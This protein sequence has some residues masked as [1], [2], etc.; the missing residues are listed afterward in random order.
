MFVTRKAYRRDV[1][2]LKAKIE[3]LSQ[4][5]SSLESAYRERSVNSE[6]ANPEA[7]ENYRG[8]KETLVAALTK[9]IIGPVRNQRDINDI[10]HN[11]S[12]ILGVNDQSIPRSVE[13][14]N[15]HNESIYCYVASI[16][17]Y[18]RVQGNVKHPINRVLVWSLKEDLPETRNARQ[19]SLAELRSFKDF[20]PCY[21]ERH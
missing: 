6:T 14:T 21:C 12:K 1:K 19:V 11:V 2:E 5:V 17:R 4:M 8:S 18:R 13:G 15:M 10:L 20:E 3:S 7:T 9:S 16:K